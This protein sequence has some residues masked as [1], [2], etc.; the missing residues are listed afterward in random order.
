[1]PFAVAARCYFGYLFAT[2]DAGSDLRKDIA[3]PVWQCRGETE[4]SS[5]FPH[6]TA[7]EEAARRFWRETVDKNFGPAQ[8]QG[9]GKKTIEI[10]SHVVAEYRWQITSDVPHFWSAGQ[11]QKI[12]DELFSKYRRLSTGALVRTP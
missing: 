5:V 10:W 8:V 11:A 3:L 9:D 4:Q 7:D 12:W 1:L 2:R 6:G